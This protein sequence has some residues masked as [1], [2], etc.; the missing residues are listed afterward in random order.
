MIFKREYLEIKNEIF[1]E[2]DNYIIKARI[3]TKYEKNYVII[4]IEKRG[5]A[6]DR[7]IKNNIS[8]YFSIFLL[9]QPILDLLTGFS[10]H[11]LK[12]N[13]TIGIIVR[14]L[15]LIMMIISS[16]FIFK[17]KKLLIPYSIIFLYIIFY[18]VGIFLYKD[19][20]N[21]FSEIQGAIF[22]LYYLPFTP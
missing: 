14:V 21:L 15:F 7:K 22:L 2:K 12:I 18:T 13:L 20:R 17:K 19:G 1:L 4:E 5:L 9:C 8:I 16:I 6:M 3:F 10:L 11:T